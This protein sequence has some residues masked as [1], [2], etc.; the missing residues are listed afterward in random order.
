MDERTPPTSVATASFDTELASASPSGQLSHQPA[1]AD[2]D[3]TVVYYGDAESVRAGFT[4]ALSL[5]QASSNLLL[6][7]IAPLAG[8]LTQE[9][10]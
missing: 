8:R 3:S 7:D 10:N 1:T 5:M 6:S 4:L 9:D 2:A